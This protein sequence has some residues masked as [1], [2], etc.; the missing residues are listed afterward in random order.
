MGFLQPSS[1]LLFHRITANSRNSRPPAT[2]ASLN[3]GWRYLAL[4]QIQAR[5]CIYGDIYLK[6]INGFVLAEL[7]LRKK[8]TCHQAGHL[9]QARV[10]GGQPRRPSV[11]ESSK[12]LLLKHPWH[13]HP[14]LLQASVFLPVLAAPLQAFPESLWALAKTQI[15]QILKTVISALR[16]HNFLIWSMHKGSLLVSQLHKA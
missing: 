15:C 3:K 6:L 1:L 14:W 8:T 5:F 16:T 2:P 9:V 4:R 7:T 12:P 10:P 13:E 11:S